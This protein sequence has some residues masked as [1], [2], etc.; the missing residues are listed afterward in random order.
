MRSTP[1]NRSEVALLHKWLAPADQPTPLGG[2]CAAKAVWQ[3]P[4]SRWS[5][6]AAKYTLDDAWS[7][8]SP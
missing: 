6:Y 2:G 7:L 8:S 3:T 1:H 4:S 5:V